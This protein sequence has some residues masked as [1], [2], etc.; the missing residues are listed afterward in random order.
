MKNIFKQLGCSVSE[1]KE[2]LNS[3]KINLFVIHNND[4]TI[5]WIWPEHVK[6]PLFLKIYT[7]SGSRSKLFSMV[8]ELIF[9]LKLQ[10]IF[11]K[12]KQL[13]IT[14]NTPSFNFDI[15]MQWAIFKG[16]VGPNNKSVVYIKKDGTDSFIK[17]ANT[18][19]AKYLI[20]KEAIILNRLYISNIE[21]F[22]FP[23]VY[24]IKNNL[25]QLSDISKDANRTNQLSNAHINALIEMNELTSLKMKYSDN[26]SWNNL[27]ND[28]I[29]LNNTQDSRMPK[30]MIRKLNTL[31]QQINENEEIEVCLSHGD[32][33]PWNMFVKNDY[34]HIYDWEL[35]DPF[36]PL[37]FDLFHFIIQQGIL[38]QHKN[39][40]A[41]KQDIDKHVNCESFSQLSKFK[42]SDRDMYLKLYL[43]F[44]TVFYLKL[45]AVQPVWHKQIFW[46]F[47]VWNEAL[48]EFSSN[49][50]NQR[51]LV[52]MDLF[53]FLL[54]KKYATIKFQN[55]YPE[56]LSRFSDVDM[57]IDKSVNKDLY[58]YLTKHPLVNTVNMVS[59]SFMASQQLIFKNGDLLSIDLIWKLKRKG[60]EILNTKILLQNN[61]INSYGVKMLDVFDN[62][63]YIALFYTLNNKPIPSKYNYYEEIISKSNTVLDKQLFPLFI[64]HL[65]DKKNI[66]KFIKT[67]KNNRWFKGLINQFNYI[68]DSV[69]IPFINSGTIIT[70]SGVD[71]AGKSTIIDNLKYKVEKQLRKRVVVLRHRPSFLPI[72]SCWTKGKIVSEQEASTNLPHSGTNKS[73]ISSLLRFTYYYLDYLIGQFLVHIKYVWRGYV[74]I[75]DRYY[76]DFMNDSKRSNI[77]LPKFIFKA[78]FM[79]LMK[80]KFNFFLYADSTTILN[81]K[82]E[83]N[84][85]TIETLTTS[86]LNQFNELDSKHTDSTYLS[87]NNIHLNETLNIVFDKIVVKNVA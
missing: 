53:D 4:G 29:Q 21:T 38:V 31:F 68:I 35:A 16:T 66:L 30:G 18:E 56:Q 15:A 49:T 81:R 23:E 10:S 86:Y 60:L 19:K 70:F 77:I 20:E 22:V 48:S 62:A 61:Y 40:V 7:V 43:I 9:I 28:L 73:I 14:E 45:Y 55:M 37:G 85:E 1:T 54:N 36:K 69:K 3:K 64:D 87:I 12:K 80:P 72:L 76:F 8:I 58:K 75:Y 41:I 39:W 82:K 25:L 71:G 27:K 52:L 33:T 13:F 11:F 32:F 6:K 42:A 24:S 51:E 44:N 34:L 83:L 74:V 59:K 63:R 26:E 84:R 46:L 17:I 47:N 5:R 78:G 50:D 2:H 79:L 65:H 67:Q 57:C